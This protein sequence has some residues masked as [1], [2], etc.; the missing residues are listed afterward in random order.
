[1]AS[2][3]QVKVVDFDAILDDFEAAE[4]VIE[5]GH[6]VIAEENQD[7][8]EVRPVQNV[9]NVGATNEEIEP[10]E[11]NKVE[12]EEEDDLEIVYVKESNKMAD[13]EPPIETEKIKLPSP[14][15]IVNNSPVN[16]TPIA[17]AFNRHH[18][19]QVTKMMTYNHAPRLNF[20]PHNQAYFT[21]PETARKREQQQPE[22]FLKMALEN[23]ENQVD[24]FINVK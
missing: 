3:T 14:S 18:Y 12:D 5:A 4:E 23:Q 7:D 17:E 15:V 10:M 11:A 9:Q 22:S 6:S 2:K 19:A 8:D 21:C 24:S 1:M 20:Y 16:S 13:S